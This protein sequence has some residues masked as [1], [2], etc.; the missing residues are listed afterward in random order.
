MSKKTRKAN[1]DTHEI[2][3]T[4]NALAQAAFA[5]ATVTGVLMQSLLDILVEGG[6]L[7]QSDVRKLYESAHAYI[8]GDQMA[9]HMQGSAMHQ[10]MLDILRTTAAGHRV[11]LKG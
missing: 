6:T 7:S 10:M 5:H 9:D 8:R 11:Q 4:A 3:G 2:A 1:E